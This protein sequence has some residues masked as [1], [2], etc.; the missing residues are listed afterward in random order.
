MARLKGRERIAAERFIADLRPSL[1]AVA[2]FIASGMMLVLPRSGLWDPAAEGRTSRY[3]CG[4]P[5]FPKLVP[6]ECYGELGDGWSWSV[7][8]ATSGIVVLASPLVLRSRLDPVR[9]RGPQ[10]AIRLIACV[11]V[12]PAVMFFAAI[13]L[14]W[15]FGQSRLALVPFYSRLALPICILGVI[16]VVALL[17]RPTRAVGAAL[18]IGA[19]LSSLTVAYERI[20][21]TNRNSTM[22]PLE[23]SLREVSQPLGTAMVARQ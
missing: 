19:F 5:A 18:I 7:A 12:P 13:Q 2:F 6:N 8:F 14:H 9:R 4:S 10:H 21:N 11:A 3:D 1:L 17:R 15:G 20:L 22:A 23:V 16:A